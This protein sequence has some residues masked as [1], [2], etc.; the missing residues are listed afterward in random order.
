MKKMYMCTCL[1]MFIYTY[2][3]MDKAHTYM[4]KHENVYVYL[5]I[6]THLLCLCQQMHLGTCVYVNVDMCINIVCVHLYAVMW[7]S[8]TVCVYMHVHICI[9]VSFHVCF[10]KFKSSHIHMLIYKYINIHV[11]THVLF[12]CIC[13][14]LLVP[15]H[16]HIF[17]DILMHVP[18][19]CKHV[20]N[21]KCEHI[22]TS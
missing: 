5:C 20:H 1:C 2:V 3:H 22:C 11:Y 9:H 4:Q 10:N 17:M 12:M 18:Y 19:P 7:V 14:N 15:K 8:K 21:E 13:D 16:V 6:W